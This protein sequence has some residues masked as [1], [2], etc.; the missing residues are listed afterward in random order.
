MRSRR[1]FIALTS[2]VTGLGLLAAACSNSNGLPAA[3]LENTVDTVSLFALT[4]TA[5]ADP[6]G[7]AVDGKRLVRIDQSPTADFVF[8]FDAATGRPSLYPTGAI[9]LGSAS[10]L[11]RATT[12]FDAITIAPTGGY[13][14]DSAFALDTGTVLL[15]RSRPTLC[16]YGATLSFYAK[17]RVLAVDS[18]ARRLDFE[19]LADE[20]C[21][22]LG[23]E[24]GLPSR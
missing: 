21:G 13:V 16:V 17:V 12:G 5:I 14:F 24:P 7:Y 3:S 20:N 23:L 19:I 9:H 11:Q 10:A 2:A 6:S 1:W 22:Y 4:G 18:T 15:V 8:D